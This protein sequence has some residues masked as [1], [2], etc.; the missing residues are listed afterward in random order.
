MVESAAAYDYGAFRRD[1]ALLAQRYG[2]LRTEMLGCSV[3]GR[4]LLCVR[5][6][7]GPRRV[8]INA[9]FH[10]N[11]WITSLVLMSVLEELAGADEQNSLFAGRSARRLLANNTLWLVP[12]VNPDG[13]ELVLHGPCSAPPLQ[14]GLLAQNG[15]SCDFSGWKA[16]IRGIDLNDQFPAHWEEERARRFV[17]EPGPRDYGG[18]AP[19]TESEAQ[20]IALLTLDVDFHR[21][22]ALHT[23]GEEIYWNYRECEPPEAEVLAARMAAASGYKA[24]KLADSDAGYKDWFIQLYRRPG[25]T[26]ELGCGVN[27]LPVSQLPQLLGAAR[28]IIGELLE[29]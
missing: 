10:A 3:M 8:H 28:A 25:F 14:C 17:P 13:V 5:L 29:D 20:A 15:G 12:M 22:M 11:E 4:E 18:E 7:S 24:V 23:Q 19:L 1:L 27:P 6:G 9:A 21:A 2:Q 16:N 26:I